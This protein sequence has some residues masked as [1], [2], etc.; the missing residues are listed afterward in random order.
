MLTRHFSKSEL[1]CKCCKKLEINEEFIEK[2]EHLR[3]STGRP[4]IINSGYRCQE[5]NKMVGGRKTS[6]HILGRAADINT[7]GLTSEQLYLFIATAL[8]IGFTGVGIGRNYI[9]IDNRE[10]GRKLWVY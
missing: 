1:A 8:Q 4:I 5:H 10:K 7:A 3:F 6:Q 9:H 2:L